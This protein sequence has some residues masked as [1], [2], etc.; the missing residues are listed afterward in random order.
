MAERKLIRK[1]IEPLEVNETVEFKRG[2]YRASSIRMICSHI[3]ADTYK[4]YSVTIG[5]EIVVVKRVS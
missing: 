4:C 3:K 1:S 5:D 2:E